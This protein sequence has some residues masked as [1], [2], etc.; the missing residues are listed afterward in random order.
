M[1]WLTNYNFAF[2]SFSFHWLYIV[3]STKF[4][5][6]QLNSTQLNCV[7]LD[8]DI[9]FRM[10]WIHIKWMLVLFI[11]VIWW[12]HKKLINHFANEKFMMFKIVIILII[13]HLQ[14]SI[15]KYLKIRS[16]Y[17]YKIEGK[18]SFKCHQVKTLL[19]SFTSK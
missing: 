7:W 16:S 5:W 4:N 13:C 18:D 1:V 15:Q 3:K 9:Q 19:Y 6:I 12:Y 10:K 14:L 2:V 17:T 8:I 11:Y